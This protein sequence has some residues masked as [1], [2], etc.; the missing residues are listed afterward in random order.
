MTR[1]EQPTREESTIATADMSVSWK[2]KAALG[3]G[4]LLLALTLFWI[5]S[6]LRATRNMASAEGIV[7]RFEDNGQLRSYRP[8]IRF[9]SARGDQREVTANTSSSQPDYDIGQ[10]VRIFYD[11]SDINQHAVVDDFEQRWFPVLVASVL[12]LTWCAIAAG[13][14]FTERRAVLRAT[15]LPVARTIRQRKKQLDRLSILVTVIP[16]V[17]GSGFLLGAGASLVHELHKTQAFGRAKGEVV[18]IKQNRTTYNQNARIYSAVVVFKTDTGR[19]IIFAQ[20]SSTSHIGYEEGDVVDVL[21]DRNTPERAM[22]DSFW[23]HWGLAIILFAIGFPF[24]AIGVF[25]ALTV[26]FRRGR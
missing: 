23:E 21:Y 10:R 8:V 22:I 26:D 25:F 4:L 24:F 5:G 11:E 12:S 15:S 7:V 18:D 13:V 17:L 6:T 14:Y 20:G 1:L 19:E 2:T 16:V 9:T 3:V